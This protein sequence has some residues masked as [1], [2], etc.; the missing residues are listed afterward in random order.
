MP[1]KIRLF[2]LL[3][4]SKLLFCSLNAAFSF[5]SF[6]HSPLRSLNYDVRFVMAAVLASDA[7]REVCARVK[8]SSAVFFSKMV[9]LFVPGVYVIKIIIIMLYFG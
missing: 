8:A 3:Y 9:F 2:F 6:P 7:A 1:C 5:L 4:S